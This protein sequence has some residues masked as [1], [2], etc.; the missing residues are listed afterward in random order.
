[1]IAGYRCAVCGT[2][3]DIA[4]VHPWR[5]P[6]ATD[7]DWRHLLR[8]VGRGPATAWR[9]F[10][11][12]HGMT[13][14]ACDARYSALSAA[15]ETVDGTTPHVTPFARHGALS[16]RLGFSERGGVWVKD[17]TGNVAG[18]H[19]A[20]H[21]LGT[22]LHL[23]VAEDLGLAS[24]PRARLAIASCGN[25]ALAA[26]TLAAAVEWPIDV[27]VP[28]HAEGAV[29][30]RLTA[31][32]ASIVVCPRRAGDPPGDP[33]FRAFR[34]AV[35]AGSVPFTVQGP[36]NATCLDT[37]RSI[38]WEIAAAGVSL[39]R[40]FVQVGGGALATCVGDGFAD[41]GVRP[42]L[43]VVQTEGAAP[44]ARA[45]DRWQA[46]RRSWADCMWPW[47]TPPRS[48]AE[49]ILDDET[50]DWLGVVEALTATG[51]SAIVVPEA[52][53][54]AAHHVAAEATGIGVSVTG[55]AGLAGLIAGRAVVGDHERVGVIFS[56]A[57]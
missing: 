7:A 9:A 19:K 29:I 31:P 38:A 28:E 44:M 42:R 8:L 51:G 10:A 40:V 30:E 53:V 33:C 11:G 3:V 15:I 16:A 49:G 32:G 5:C 52:T 6:R 48:A 43:H 35:A 24:G 12:A 36:M 21:L 47:E 54:V 17:E 27:F 25:A 45:W 39:D 46:G 23:L 55:A 41:A 34:G 18:S 26:A 1:M 57:A 22:L 2:T 14:A 37:G 20:R 13:D 50:Y 56:G 4:T